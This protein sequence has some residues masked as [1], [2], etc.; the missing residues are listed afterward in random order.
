MHPGWY[1]ARVVLAL[2]KSGKGSE[3]PLHKSWPQQ[4]T[5]TITS[6]TALNLDWY[7][8]LNGSGTKWPLSYWTL[9]RTPT[10][11]PL[12]FVPI[13]NCAS[14]EPRS[15]SSYGRTTNVRHTSTCPLSLF[16]CSL[17]DAVGVCLHKSVTKEFPYLLLSEH[18]ISERWL[19]ETP[20]PSSLATNIPSFR[21]PDQ[22]VAI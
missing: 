12:E 19:V 13:S 8:N 4:I 17:C 3:C 16:Y 11:T 20:F 6:S 18:R 7:F 21:Y 14:L 5:I 22:Y 9:K 15:L 2:I 10:T 1:I